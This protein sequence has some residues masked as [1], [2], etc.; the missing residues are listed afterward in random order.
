LTDP[1]PDIWQQY[2]ARII[3]AARYAF[4]NPLSLLVESA[5][6][7]RIDGAVSGWLAHPNQWLGLHKLTHGVLSFVPVA[8]LI[9]LVGWSFIAVARRLRK[10][11][12]KALRRK[13][14]ELAEKRSIAESRYDEESYQHIEYRDDESS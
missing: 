14:K 4:P 8:V 3:D 5:E 13:Q 1:W 9:F 11:P 2:D 12:G 6:Y 7:L 10:W